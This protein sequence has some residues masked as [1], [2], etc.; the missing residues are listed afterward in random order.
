VRKLVL[1]AIVGDPHAFDEL[2]HE[3][4]TAVLDESAVEEVT[5]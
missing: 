5:M 2:H 4:R 1:E 3:I